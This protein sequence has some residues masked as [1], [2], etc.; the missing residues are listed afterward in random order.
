L[1]DDD[2]RNCFRKGELPDAKWVRRSTGA[3]FAAARRPD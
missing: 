3:G 2:G 1:H